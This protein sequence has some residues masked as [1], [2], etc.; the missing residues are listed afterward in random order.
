MPL[1]K[2]SEEKGPQISLLE[3]RKSFHLQYCHGSPEQGKSISG[4]LIY[5]ELFLQATFTPHS[6]EEIPYSVNGPLFQ[7]GQ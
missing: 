3:A 4:S 5:Q 6:Q 7:A 1:Y 2:A